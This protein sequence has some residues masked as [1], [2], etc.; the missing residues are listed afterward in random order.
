MRVAIT[1]ATGNVGT[2][3]VQALSGDSQVSSVL[4]LSRR[5]PGW[6]PA[7]VTWAEA[8]V[9]HDPLTA[10]FDGADAV[11]HLAWQIQPTHR[12]LRTWE[13][14]VVGTE[15]VLSAAAEAGVAVVVCASSWGAYSPGPKDR[16]VDESWPTDGWPTA[17]Y[18]REKAYVERLLDTFE[19]DH[20]TCRLVRIRPGFI[21]KRSSAAEQ[22]RLFAGPL[23]PSPLARSRVPIVPD[24]EGL[25]LQV[26]H[27]DDAAEAYRLA[28]V[29]P[30]R[31]AFNIAAEPVLDAARLAELL[32]GRIVPVP[33]RLARAAIAALWRL[34]LVPASPYLVD[35]VLRLP[36]M[37]TQRARDELGWSERHTSQEVITEFLGGLAD[38][39][40]LETPPLAPGPRA[41][42]LASAGRMGRYRPV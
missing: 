15:R 3:L 38:E 32:G 23:L 41:R 31:G 26:L 13:V 27:S 34:R 14:N 24:L 42:L 17:G 22:R 40:G 39:S 7:K 11:V 16:R 28:L 2:S 20:P 4:G 18:T 33:R 21:F 25:R 6:E 29:R 30:V 36:V 9:R 5:R 12:P 19:R 35:A 10:H 8:D 37:S 1:G